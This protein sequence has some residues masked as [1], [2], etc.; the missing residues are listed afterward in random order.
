MDFDD[1]GQVDAEKELDEKCVD[2]TYFVLFM[3]NVTNRSFLR[4][5]LQ[6]IQIDLTT[7]PRHYRSTNSLQLFSTH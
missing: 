7:I 6:G 4:T 3:R 1:S 5:Y 2:G